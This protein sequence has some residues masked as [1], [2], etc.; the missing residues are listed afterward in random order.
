M[1]YNTGIT[2]FYRDL[3]SL[4]DGTSMFEKCS[5]LAS[6]DY[7]DKYGSGLVGDGNRYTSL[8]KG[9]GKLKTS[10]NMFKGT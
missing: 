2:S 1:F 8:F 4:E 3:Y 6:V 9:Y 7:T 10:T 5:S